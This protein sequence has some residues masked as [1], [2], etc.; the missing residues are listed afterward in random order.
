MSINIFPYRDVPEF[1][2][3]FDLYTTRPAMRDTRA[4][5]EGAFG[6]SQWALTS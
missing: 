3:K 1:M 4:S 2:D 6:S 5:L